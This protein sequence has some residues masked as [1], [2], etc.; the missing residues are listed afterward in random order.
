MR[1]RV[2]SGRPSVRRC[3]TGPTPVVRCPER[4]RTS[5]SSCST[6][7]ASPISAATAR[8]SPRRPSMPSPPGACATPGFHTTA[9]CSTTRAALLTGRNHHSVGVGC[10]ANFDSGFPGYRG[11][12]AR[13]AGTIAE[14]LQPA[15]LSQ[16]HD[17]Q[18]ARHAADRDGTDRA[19]RRL[20]ARA[21][22]RPLL[23]LPRRRDRPVRPRAGP[24]QPPRRP[25]GHVRR[26][27]PPHRS[28]SSTRRSTSS[29]T[30]GPE[31]QSC[32]G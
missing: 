11:K 20:A 30:T 19:V 27:L 18:V 1:S 13:A 32:R 17:G 9:M 2:W 5:W 25:A 22:L 7:S 14:M 29:R 21:G 24:R 12:I 15:R 3:R 26:R 16:L 4:H 28:T 10:L 6:T 8:R 31:H 23:R